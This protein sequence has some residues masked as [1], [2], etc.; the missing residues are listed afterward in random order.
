MPQI[1][2]RLI[3]N[4]EFTITGEENI[5]GD[6]NAIAEE[7]VIVEE[8]ITDGCVKEVIKEGGFTAFTAL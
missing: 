8:S 2:E 4:R 1:L 5:T 6:K 3:P 7:T